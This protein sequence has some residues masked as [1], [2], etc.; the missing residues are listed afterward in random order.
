MNEIKDL[1]SQ[2]PTIAIVGSGPSGCYLA[3]Y[4]RKRWKEA[5]I[6]I[7]DR[8][9]VPYGLVRFG[10]AP[11]HLGTKAVAR[12]FDRLFEREGVRFIGETE[13]GN[14]L[15]LQ[16]LRDAF[17]IVVLASGLHGD[18]AL[19]V[20]GDTLPGVHGAGRIT[21]LIN[22]H[23]GEQVDGLRGG[24]R[25]AIV[26]NGNVAMDLVRLL[27]TPPERLLELGVAED[28]VRALGPGSVKRIDIVGRSAAHDAKF[29]LAMLRELTKL[30]DVSFVAEDLADE[31]T[32]DAEGIAK[33]DAVAEIAEASPARAARSVHFHFGWTP[34]RVIGQD[35]VQS[36]AFRSTGDENSTLLLDVE[37]VLT[38][39]GFE[40]L[41]TSPI[42]RGHHESAESELDKGYLSPGLYCAGWLRR[43]PRGTIP[44]NR[45]DSKMVAD[46]II[47]AVDTAQLVPG[48]P[49]LPALLAHNLSNTRHM[50]ESA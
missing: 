27:L 8:L 44:Q 32:A 5:E 25:I 36:I 45:V 18:R 33:R 14:G 46:A 49:G 2:S 23:P 1:P 7:F 47:E 48:K 20:P 26:G 28:V 17:D 3:Q 29:D 4:L 31:G 34:E 43:G 22:G 24:E 19:G 9:P 12:Q 6:V 37:G 35:K 11:D 50:E 41:T 16:E 39:I 10:V 13:I 38:A 21:R 40:E 42:R 30:P 15:M